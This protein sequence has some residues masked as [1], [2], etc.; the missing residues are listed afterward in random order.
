MVDL[1][2]DVFYFE[3][4]LFIYIRPCKSYANINDRN[5]DSIKNLCSPIVDMKIFEALIYYTI[6]YESWL[7]RQ[8]VMTEKVEYW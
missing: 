3:F 1:V 8:V 5:K 2:F 7:L 6:M 4:M